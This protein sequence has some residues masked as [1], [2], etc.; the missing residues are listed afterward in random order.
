M[1]KQT[2]ITILFTLVGITGQC[3]IHYRLEGNIGMPNFTGIMEV[4]DVLMQQAID[5]IEVV[6]GIISPK[7]GNVCACRHD[8]SD[9]NNRLWLS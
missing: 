5:T 2:I 7:E 1:K 8:Q 9:C 3:Q 4:R 6:N